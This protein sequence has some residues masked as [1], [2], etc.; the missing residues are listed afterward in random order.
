MMC[1]MRVITADKVV[2]LEFSQMRETKEGILLDTRFFTPDGQP[3]APIATRLR[4]KSATP[5]EW[6]FENPNG[7][8]PK[9][10]SV[11]RQGQDAMTAHSDLIDSKGKA[12]AIDSEWKRLPCG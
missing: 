7:T 8:Q 2:W 12:S 10:Q 9:S 6:V 11:T 4:L 1:M 5:T 3:A